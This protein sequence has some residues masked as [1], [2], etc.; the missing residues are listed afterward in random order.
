MKK[1]GLD[2]LGQPGQLS[3]GSAWRGWGAQPSAQVM[4][5][6]YGRYRGEGGKGPLDIP[7]ASEALVL[8]ALLSLLRVRL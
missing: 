1:N 2:W 6:Q 3:V 4:S 5:L 7:L 8:T